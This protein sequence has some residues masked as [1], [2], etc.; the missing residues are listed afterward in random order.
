MLNNG[1]EKILFVTQ[2]LECGGV[3]KALVNLLNLVDRNTY[4][5][6]MLV[7]ENSGKFRDFF[8][9]WINILEYDCPQY[10]KM[11]ANYYRKPQIEAGDHVS[12]KMSKIG[13]SLIHYLNKFTTKVFKKNVS[14]RV[15]FEKYKKRNDF[16]DYDMLVDFHGYGV[17]TTY[18]AAH[19]K[20]TA[21]KVSW[22][23]EETIYT[24]YKYIRGCYK[25]FDRIFGNC[26]DSCNNFVATFPKCKE[27]VGVYYNFLDIGEIQKKA[28]EKDVSLELDSEFNIVS[29]GRVSEQKSFY[30]AV[31]AAQ[32]LK[33]KGYKFKWMIIGDG[34]QYQELKEETKKKGLHKC[35]IFHGFEENPYPYIADADLYVQTSRA[36]GFCTT[37]SEAVILGK[38]IVSTR[39]GGIEEQLNGNCGGMITGHTSEEIAE[40]IIQL[41]ED[42]DKLNQLAQ[43]NLLKKMDYEKEIKKLY[44]VL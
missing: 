38:P 6:E 17:Y 8:P 27:K 26:I 5:C 30:R 13:W 24:A 11:M 31:E 40:A 12:T 33:E 32:R 23:H 21:K 28:K 37:I 20:T 9:Q 1:E 43:H 7:I 18:L 16:S 42:K 41:I 14:Y 36:E 10:V 2:Q 15:M 25:H 39:V 22:I 35:L 29:V 3:E 4:D 34:E 44:Q 19:Q